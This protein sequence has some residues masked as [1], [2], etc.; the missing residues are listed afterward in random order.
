MMSRLDRFIN[1]YSRL[2]LST[3]DGTINRGE[4]AGYCT[5]LDILDNMIC[6]NIDGMISREYP[7]DNE[8]YVNDYER[9][10]I[11]KTYDGH[12]VTINQSIPDEVGIMVHAWISPFFDV[13]MSGN[14]VCWND[15]RAIAWRELDKILYRWSM[16]N[17]MEVANG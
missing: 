8:N 16:I 3:E 2:G 11:D 4:I 7:L 13:Y 6:V 9:V 1:L 12:S 10:I 5:G 14:G 17:T 15:R